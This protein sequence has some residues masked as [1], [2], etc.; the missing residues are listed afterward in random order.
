MGFDPIWWWAILSS[1]ALGL[2]SCASGSMPLG[3]TDSSQEQLPKNTLAKNNK[4]AIQVVTTFLPITQFTKAVAGDR[5]QVTQLLPPNPAP[6]EYQVKP[7]DVQTLA[8]ADVLVQNGLEIE[9]FLDDLVKN[10]QNANLRTSRRKFFRITL[11]GLK[12]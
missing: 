9:E 12:N 7:A 4:A 8:K 5:A 3:K 6:H 1:L 10:A 2:G 11:G